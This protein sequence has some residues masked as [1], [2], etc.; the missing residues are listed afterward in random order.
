MTH[1]FIFNLHLVC[2]ICAG[3]FVT[4]LAATGTIMAFEPELDRVLHHRLAYVRAGRDVHSLAE[5][6]N[7]VSQKFNGEPVV[8]YFLAP[9]PGLAWQVALPSG[10]VY[11]NQHTGEILGERSREQTFLGFVHEVH[12][13]LGGGEFGKDILK[14][15]TLATLISLA[16]G[17]YLWWPAKRVRVRRN[18]RGRGF[19]ADLHN[20]TG[21]IALAPLALITATGVVLGFENEL[22]PAVDRLTA[23]RTSAVTRSLQ[24]SS[25]MSA[26]AITPDQAVA[27]ARR[28]MPEA[29]PY[30]LQ[31]PKYGGSYRVALFDPQKSI[32]ADR[33]VV[34]LDSNGNV[35]SQT[36]SSDLSKGDRIFATNEAIHTGSIWGFPSRIATCV[37]S[38]AAIVQASSGWLMWLY[39]KK[40]I[41][42]PNSSERT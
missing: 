6:G 14:W 26:L 39:R 4:I 27:I 24:A 15:S 17:L 3:A 29:V 11:V 22:A 40:V 23:S 20:T 5:L 41:P 2:A 37:T 16:T 19:W 12:V 10:I 7:A 28:I 1:R 25:P 34:V 18:R 9:E 21:I 13:R 36:Q 32:A 38:M 30:R 42:A 35:L 8:A 31:M 33:N